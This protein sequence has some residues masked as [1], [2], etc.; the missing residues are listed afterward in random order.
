MLILL[1]SVA[2]KLLGANADLYIRK[3][4]SLLKDVKERLEAGGS[5]ICGCFID[6]WHYIERIAE[7][8]GIR[9]ALASP[10]LLSETFTKN[11][12]Q[13]PELLKSPTT[14]KEVIADC[15]RK[16]FIFRKYLTRFL[17]SSNVSL[18][19]E[20][21]NS[22]RSELDLDVDSIKEL[23][24]NNS[25]GIDCFEYKDE[26]LYARVLIE[27][28]DELLIIKPIYN[29]KG[30]TGN[31]LYTIKYNDLIT[32]CSKTDTRKI[33]LQTN[34]DSIELVFEDKDKAVEV[35]NKIREDRKKSKE[36]QLK[37]VE[38]YLANCKLSN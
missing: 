8:R 23:L 31:L 26:V 20:L 13:I 21:I 38:E 10:G 30:I 18:D 37:K 4:N 24:H 16:F 15:F 17:E 27:Q 1:D 5:T 25:L 29:K 9:K 12:V 34:N 36:R 7:N 28:A 6:Q 35:K 14:S 19:A 3:Y 32:S 33:L 11:G 2:D 22:I